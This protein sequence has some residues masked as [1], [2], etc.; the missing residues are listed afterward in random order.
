MQCIH[1]WLNVPFVFPLAVFHLLKNRTGKHCQTFDVYQQK[2]LRCFS[3]THPG[4][5][6]ISPA[7]T[8]PSN[9]TPNPLSLPFL[10]HM[11][12]SQP[13]S[14][15]SRFSFFLDIYKCTQLNTGSCR[16]SKLRHYQVTLRSNIDQQWDHEQDHAIVHFQLVDYEHKIKIRVFKADNI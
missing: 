7:G 5:Y 3:F 6:W 9:H 8:W 16:C 1:K 13:F 4:E 12:Q 2:E 10:S 14:R 15:F 11:F